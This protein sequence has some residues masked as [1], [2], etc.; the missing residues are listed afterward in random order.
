MTD[1]TISL[2]ERIERLGYAQETEVKLYGA[3][4]ELVSDPVV[5]GDKL[6][7]IG[8][9]LALGSCLCRHTSAKRPEFKCLQSF[10][11]FSYC[12]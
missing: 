8:T 9:R 1:Q 11:P 6:V 7:F 12:S 3:I 5:M 4:F 10:A 2:S